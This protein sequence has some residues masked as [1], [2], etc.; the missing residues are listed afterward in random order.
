[1]EVMLSCEFFIGVGSGLSWVAW[2]LG[3]PTVL[4]SGFSKPISEFGGDNVVRIFNSSVCN[5]CYNRFRLDAG[6]WNW[7]PDQKD[8]ER[9]FECTKSITSKMVIDAIE[10]KGWIEKMEYVI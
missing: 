6:D 3:I 8:T 2:T 4:I 9:Q 10:S 1:M 7:C 5:G